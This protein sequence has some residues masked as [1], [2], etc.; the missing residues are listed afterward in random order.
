MLAPAAAGLAQH[1]AAE[2]DDQAALLGDRDELRGRQQ[3]AGGVVPAHQRLE[4]GDPLRVQV[5]GRL[6]VQHQLRPRGSPA[7][8]RRA[9]PA[10]RAPRRAA[11]P[12]RPRRVPLPRSLAQYIATSALRS[13][14]SPVGLARHRLRPCRCWPAPSAWCRRPR[15]G[16]R[17]PASSR[18]ATSRARCRRRRPPCSTR[19]LVAA[20]P[21][22][23]V[24]LA[25][26]GA[27]PLGDGDQQLVADAVAEAV[28][29]VLEVVEVE[30]QHDERLGG[31]G[32][33]GAARGRAGRRTAAGWRSPVSGVVER[34][35]AQLLLERLPVGDVADGEHPAA[36]RR[37]RPS[38]W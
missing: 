17:G 14:S 28:V 25:D 20:E 22:G 36:A 3:P 4:A 26:G 11:R 24:A 35:V 33:G 5:D 30:E 18:S 38:G 34:L 12:R 1:P 7:A 13:V 2:R 19:E 31:A 32:R 21:G 8:A 6:V 15:P 9:A 16:R 37:R 29:D 23:G 10:A 27:D